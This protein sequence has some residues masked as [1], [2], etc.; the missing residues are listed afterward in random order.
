MNLLERY[1][2]WLIR[3]RY[4]VLI[5]TPLLAGLT[6]LGFPLK[7]DA[8]Y[9]M[10]FD[11]N[12]P[13][14]LA[15][16]EIENT[17][18]K[19]DNVMFVLAPDDG[20]IFTRKTLEAVQWLTK[21]AWQFPYSIRVDSV[22]N[23]Q[24]S[25]AE[26]DDIIVGDLIPDAGTISEAD[27]ARARKIAIEEP[28]LIDKLISPAA[29]VTGVNV[30]VQFSGE[31]R[32]REV[33]EVVA[34]ARDLKRD[35]LANYPHMEVYLV[36]DVPFNNAFPEASKQDMVTLIPVMFLVIVVVLWLLLRFISGVFATVLL[37]AFSATMAMG[38]SGLIGIL[39]TPVSGVALIV[40]L[41]LA[42]ADGV[43]ILTTLK[44]NLDGRK[45]HA[46][47]VESLR[48]NFQP[49]FLTSV[50]TAIGFLSLNFSE[51]PPFRDL[52]NIIAMG[53]MIA[54]VLSISFLPALMAIL[55]VPSKSAVTG[56]IRAMDRLGEFVVEKRRGLIWTMAGASL[57]LIAFLPRNELNN[58]FL[59]YFDESF[60]IRVAT[61][62]TADN[63]TG[64]YKIYHSLD[65]GEPG[66]IN[67]P[68]FLRKVEEFTDWYR[69][70]PK[71][72]HVDSIVHTLKRLNR[73]M[74]GDDP[75]WYRLPEHRE[76]AA[77]YLLLYEMSLPYGLDLNN[78]INLSK[79]ATRIMVTLDTLS[80]RE[81]LAMERRAGQWLAENALV[82][83]QAPGTGRRIMAANMSIRNLQ[84]LLVSTVSALILIS[85][86]LI[87]E[88]RSVRFGLISLIPNLL[89]V[90][91]AFGL[92]GILVGEINFTLSIV[93]LITIGIVVDDTI[94]FLSKYLRARREKNLTPPDAVRYAFHSVGVA[95]W[96]TS[97][98]LIAGF[99]VLCL[100]HYSPNADMGIMVAIT[101][102][103][104]LVTDF[105]LLP[106]LLMKWDGLETA[107]ASPEL[108][109]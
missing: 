90:A 109:Q 2:S 79:S 101:I 70:Q 9:R 40:I 83:M 84:S 3:W 71:V 81:I 93:A 107:N 6:T 73:N 69:N 21:A 44:L 61:D 92:W 36:G 48:I 75:A 88:L 7:F 62:F 32:D 43:H 58:S 35:A 52:G 106:P 26:G 67:N 55:P 24:H 66:G 37:I 41:T 49:V 47:I 34:F 102:A 76:L 16:D 39:L 4:F 45:K 77:Q 54:F 22:T 20:Q 8:D 42:I 57:L 91:M 51:V 14:L 100:S 19:D 28:L 11:E 15:L 53:I 94:H 68:E 95:L 56:E 38:L 25:Y 82:F 29:H 13:G 97:V 63:L 105:L 86:I 17:Y 10:F 27:M 85:I 103:L 99:L 74:H 5:V 80:D 64:S 98:V 87:I 50:T 89:P 104:A 72:V 18:T 65:A 108:A 46:A 78:K 31:Q 30:T 96:V 1:G 23:F 12:D 33:P 59:E 60:D